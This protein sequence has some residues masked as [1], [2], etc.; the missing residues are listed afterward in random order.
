M[1]SQQSMKQTVPNDPSNLP[2]YTIYKARIKSLSLTPTSKTS[3]S[4]ILVPNTIIPLVS[5]T[6]WGLR[7]NFCV[8]FF[9]Q[10]RMRVMVCLCTLMATRCHLEWEVQSIHTLAGL[11][12]SFCV[13]PFEF[14]SI[15]LCLPK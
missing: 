13:C 8:V 2:N 12:A 7:S 9:L 14:E 15:H 11:Q 6:G 10:S 4:S 5:M 1:A 3:S